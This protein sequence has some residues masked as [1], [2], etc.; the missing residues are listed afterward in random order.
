MAPPASTDEPARHKKA[1]KSKPEKKEKKHKKWSQE[2]PATED[3]PIPDASE[4]KKR[5]HKEVREEKREGK[6]YKKE[7][8]HEG[9]AVEA[10]AGEAGRDEKMR[11]AMEDERF[12]AARSDP[13]F[14]PMRRKEAKVALDSRFSSMMTDPRFVSSA[15]PVD[16]RG[17]RRK[18]RENPLLNYY[19]NQ[20]EE[21][22]GKEKA[23]KEK[24]KLVEDDEEEEEDKE[25]DEEGSSS[26][27]DD[28]D[29][30]VDDDDEYSV[31]SDIAHYLMGRHDDTPMVD[32]ET[33]RLAVVNMDW[34]HIKAVDL[35]MVMTSCL[36][37]GGRV[38][39]VSVYPSEFGL[40][41]MEIESTQGPAALVNANVDGKVSDDDDDDDDKNDDKDNTDDDSDE[42]ITDDDEDITDDDND[43]EE[44]DSDKENNKLRAYELNRL[45]YYYA[46][47]VCDSSATANHLYMTLDGTE[48]LKTANAFD[49]QFIPDSREFK[50][51]ARDV[52]TEAPPSYKEPDFETRALQHS[53]VKLTWDEDEP[54]RKKVLRR[55]F[56][57]DQLDELDMYLASDDSA[58]DDDDGDNS[59]D[60]GGSKRKLTKEERLAL[61]LD[62][63]DKSDE[64][65]T[66][67]QDMEITFN[68]ELEDLS[69]RVLERKSNEE[70]TVWE[71]HQEKMK[72]K[73]KA[74]KRGLQDEDDNDHYSSED[75]PD[76]DDDF[77][78]AEQSDEEPKP[79]K[80][81]KHKAKAKDKG[82]RKGKEDSTEEHLE[83]EATKEELELLVAGDQDTASGAKGYNLKRKKGKKGKKGKEESV[84]DKLP[85]IDLS[86]DDRFSAMFTSHLFAL[87]PTDPQY[88]RSAAFMRK[89]PGKPG[90]HASKAEGSSLGGTLPP[91]DAAAKNNDDQ[92][93]DGPSTEKLQ[94]LS[95]VKSLKRNLGAFKSKNK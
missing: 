80:S 33:H 70:K 55:K 20:E 42:D 56:T 22:E 41:C 45:K 72:E 4:R 53:R 6:K 30:D 59:D 38:L 52:A 61:L 17:R 63:G 62:G 11:R 13:R 65:Q 28:E 34:D 21:E 68:T 40:K 73:R 66:D 5:K 93:P 82:K 9:K 95:A 87:D 46:V 14:R 3:G 36:P 24:A 15:A 48:F 89:Q 44:V 10:E 26:S 19:L 27:D 76:E 31:G 1:K 25:Q 85:D 60:D 49:L 8:K 43:E 91:D 35:Y 16:K 78:A 58:S 75:E 88:K 84:E 79:S 71:K 81:K 23:K 47:V 86:K 83:P 54:E 2:R 32:K 74:R 77:F 50:H 29:E 12:A 64:E 51:P 7:G 90:V 39:S 18:K 67:D 94:I 92:K 69:K 57:D 37:K